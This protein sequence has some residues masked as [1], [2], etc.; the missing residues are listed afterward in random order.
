MRHGLLNT[1]AETTGERRLIAAIRARV[2]ADPGWLAVGI[3]DDA[4][5][6]APERGTLEVFTTDSVIEGVHFDPRASTRADVGWKALAVN[7]SD[8]AAMGATPRLA[9]LSLALPSRHATADLDGFLDGFLA[10]ASEA[11]VVLAGGNLARTTGPLVA[12]V[13][14]VGFV[15][16]RRLLRRGGA[17]PGD[18]LYVSGTLGAATAGLMWW[19]H[20]QDTA[21]PRDGIDPCL[22]RHRRPVPRLRLGA[23]LGRN[24]AATACIDLS[25][26]LADGVRQI[27]EASGVGA[28]IDAEALPIEPAAR[29]WFEHRGLDPVQAALSG[30][31]DYELLFTA[32]PRNRGRLATVIRQGRA[33]QVTRIGEVTRERDIVLRTQG[34]DQPLPM[35]FSHFEED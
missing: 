2:P 5:V 4:A 33:V 23:L 16:P 7:L 20:A 21:E 35:G 14:V 28:S 15:R 10:L 34:K 31:D 32:P 17:R 22:A 8:I 26:G 25:D 6:A 27:C 13:T 29:L 12:D 1:P 19:R 9:L 24:K 3:G 11:R 18:G 30:G